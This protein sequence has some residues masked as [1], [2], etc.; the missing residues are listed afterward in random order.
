MDSKPKI[1]R[2]TLESNSFFEGG[3]FYSK[4]KMFEG[5]HLTQRL[6]FSGGTSESSSLLKGGTFEPNPEMFH[7]V[8]SMILPPKKRLIATFANL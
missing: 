1:L 8:H 4:S 5:A 7:G 6:K 2:G 3:T